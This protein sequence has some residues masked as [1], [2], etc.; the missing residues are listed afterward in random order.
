[1]VQPEEPDAIDRDLDLGRL[2]DALADGALRA[3]VPGA[4]GDEPVLRYLDVE[5]RVLFDR[6]DRLLSDGPDLTA[7]ARRRH[8]HLLGARR[9]GEDDR[10]H[11]LLREHVD[12]QRR[13]LYPKLLRALDERGR[14]ELAGALE[15]ARL[16]REEAD[17][18]TS[19][20]LEP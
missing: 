9:D 15:E 19:L 17:V 14:T 2:L 18:P 13:V 3:I 16:S 5:E 11:D 8:R 7:A 6:V 12:T 20:P 4:S 1:M 10:W